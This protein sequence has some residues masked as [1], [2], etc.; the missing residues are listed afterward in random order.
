VAATTRTSTGIS[1]WLP[2]GTT[3][4]CWSTRSS[5]AWSSSSIS[6]ISSRKIVPPS[7][8]RKQPS[9]DDIAPVKDPFTWPNMWLAN[10]VPVVTAQSTGMNGFAARLPEE[11]MARAMSSFPVPLGPRIRTLD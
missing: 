5:F 6:P 8:A 3:A 4:R 10:S 2:T 7:A 9:V 1:S 11:W